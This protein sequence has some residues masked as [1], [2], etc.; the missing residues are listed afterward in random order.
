MLC[1]NCG[2]RRA[3]IHLVRVVNGTCVEEDICRQCAEKMMPFHDAERALKMSFS[4]EGIMNVGDALKNLLFPMLPELYEIEDRKTTCP[5]CG[6]E[7]AI[8]ELFGKKDKEPE[9]SG[10]ETAIEDLF[11]G[12]TKEPRDRDVIFDFSRT[13]AGVEPPKETSDENKDRPKAVSPDAKIENAA[14][15]AEKELAALAA[16]L[17]A[18]LR[19]ERYER[20]AEIRDRVTALKKIMIG[21]ESKEA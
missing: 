9:D 14:D 8:D 6:K 21:E 2:Q 5:H 11:A 13:E 15:S 17:T 12:K 7:I 20:A 16:E 18:A 4:L 1:E 10:N 19:E 3:E